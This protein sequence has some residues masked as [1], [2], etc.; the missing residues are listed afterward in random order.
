MTRC[1]NLLVQALA[2]RRKAVS[3]EHDEARM[4]DQH[5]VE[6]FSRN[7]LGRH[8][9]EFSLPFRGPELGTQEP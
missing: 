2:L 4:G 7:T 1:E 5:G 6:A 8:T 9:V 3:T